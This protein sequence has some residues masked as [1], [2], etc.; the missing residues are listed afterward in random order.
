MVRV[1]RNRVPGFVPLAPLAVSNAHRDA[2]LL[3]R[4]ADG[5]RAFG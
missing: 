1:V 2:R 5:I 3:E 4:L